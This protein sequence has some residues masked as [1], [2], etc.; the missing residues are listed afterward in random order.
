VDDACAAFDAGDCEA[1]MIE[2]E[3]VLSK[4]AEGLSTVL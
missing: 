4:E 2:A 3:I 1:A